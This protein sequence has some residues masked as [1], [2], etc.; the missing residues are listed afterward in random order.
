MESEAAVGGVGQKN[1]KAD[2]CSILCT[3]K[4]Y[5]MGLVG[6]TGAHRIHPTLEKSID[7]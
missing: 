5:K 7:F 4:V 2:R 3:P 1:Q 6:E